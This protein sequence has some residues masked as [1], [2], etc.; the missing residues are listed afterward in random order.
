[1]EYIF[2]D[3]TER[4]MDMLILRNIAENSDFRKLI[5]KNLNVANDC[6]VLKA[7]HSLAD[8]DGESDLTVVVQNGGRKTGILIEDKIN[9]VAQ[10]DQAARYTRRGNTGINNKEYDEFKVVIVAPSEYLAKNSEAQ[11]YDNQISY[12]I[13]RD[14]FNV[15]SFEYQAFERALRK[16]TGGYETKE[17][18]EITNF[19]D[20][21]Y[22]YI[23]ENYP[24][25]NFNSEKGKIKGAQCTW[26]SFRTPVKDAWIIYKS[27]KMYVDLELRGA[28]ERYQE[29]M[30]DN[31]WLLKEN[32]DIRIRKAGKSLAIE[33][34]SHYSLDCYQMFKNQLPAI[35]EAMDIVLRLQVEILPRLNLE[36]V[37][38]DK[39]D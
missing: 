33:I 19:N 13:L 28:G 12:E 30:Q 11:K 31:E 14:T 9:A 15:N 8:G 24:V 39:K 25:L 34:D 16:K 21:L 7:Y 32:Q 29:L 35:K 4:D 36:R 37:L 2:S 20:C 3:I 38:I 1:M 6:E 10:P 27:T 17:I 18:P 5:L 23:K 26:F 22:D